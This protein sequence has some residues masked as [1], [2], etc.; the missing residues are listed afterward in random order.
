MGLLSSYKLVLQPSHSPLTARPIPPPHSVHPCHVR[1][2]STC[3]WAS[4]IFARSM[5]P[6]FARVMALGKLSKDPLPLHSLRSQ[7]YLDTGRKY[8]YKPPYPCPLTCGRPSS[9]FSPHLARLSIACSS[10]CFG[11]GYICFNSVSQI[12]VLTLRR[13]HQTN[14]GGPSLRASYPLMV[15]VI[16]VGCCCLCAFPFL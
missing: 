2:P 16:C 5:E 15:H 3:I 14:H 10:P 8:L 9:P 11:H 13:T 1:L 4:S 6:G 12:R 7:D